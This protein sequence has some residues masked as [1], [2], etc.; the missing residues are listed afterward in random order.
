MTRSNANAYYN[1]ALVSV[2]IYSIINIITIRYL[3]M[4]LLENIGTY[5]HG[6]N[7]NSETRTIQLVEPNSSSY[8]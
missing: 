2:Y 8:I 6:S 3:L 4:D 7:W 5:L 1:Q